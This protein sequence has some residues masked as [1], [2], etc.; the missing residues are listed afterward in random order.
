MS[1]NT[2]IAMQEAYFQEASPTAFFSGM[3]TTR[4]QGVHT[5]EEVE[6]DVERS[7]EDVAIVVQDLSTGYRMNSTDLFSNKKFKPPIYKEAVPLNSFDLLKRN[8]GQTPFEM[9]NFR[10]NIILKMMGGMRKIEAKIRR[11][12]EIQASQ[13]KQTGIV[14][15]T[16]SSGTALYTLDYKPKSA[17]FP[18]SG[19]AW[20]AA[21]LAQKI[22]DLTALCDVIRSNGLR[23]PDQMICGSDAWENLLQTTGFLDRFFDARRADTGR[24]VPMERTG[25]GGIYRGVIELGNYK[26]DLWTY[27]GRYTDPQ[28]GVS[29]KFMD[30]GKVI[31]QS[32][33][34]RMDATWGAIPNIGQEL[35]VSSRLI[36]E[37]P[38]RM[39]SLAGNIDMFTNVWI[40]ADG[41]QLFGAVGARPL[42]IPVAIDTF[43]CLETQ[44]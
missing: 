39:T 31:I 36:P 20:G 42:L 38:G 25:S 22:A 28:T 10:A 3:F 34:G 35:G 30:P 37:L 4:P 8:P 32:S 41:E 18:T 15:L 24:I 21:T 6:I 44:L 19:T 12:V 13:I 9:P 2:T 14:T 43:G 26:L 27:E 40:S 16:D 29:T 11:A 33:T 7:E 5:S 1:T 17:H 23:D